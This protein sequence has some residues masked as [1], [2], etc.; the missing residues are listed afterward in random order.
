MFDSLPSIFGGFYELFVLLEVFGNF[1]YNFMFSTFSEGLKSLTEYFPLLTKTG[2]YDIIN[3][4][5]NK[6]SLPPIR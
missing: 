2:F 1:V 6:G 5:L 4:F 3:V